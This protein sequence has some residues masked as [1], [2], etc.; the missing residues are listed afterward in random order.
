MINLMMALKRPKH[1]G[2]KIRYVN[3]NTL[4]IKYS[5]FCLTLHVF[6]IAA[7]ILHLGTT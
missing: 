2:P 4:A 1:V 7:I 3:K 6:V 5:K